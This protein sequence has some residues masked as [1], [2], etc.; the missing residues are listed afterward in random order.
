MST[1]TLSI[2]ECEEDYSVI[3]EKPWECFDNVIIPD[4]V[5]KLGRCLFMDCYKIKNVII[6]DSV[7]SICDYVFLECD[8]LKSVTI[9]S[10]VSNISKLAFSGYKGEIN[11]L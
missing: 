5:T 3:E 6:P 10:S 7:T 2:D 4:G 1:Y 8:N 9:P 11:K